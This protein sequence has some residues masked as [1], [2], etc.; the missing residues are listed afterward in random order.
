MHE[1]RPVRAEERVSVLHRGDILTEA[2]T[3]ELSSAAL[4]SS[5]LLATAAA[6]AVAAVGTI[7]CR[8]ER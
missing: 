5:H 7:D 8:G 4:S 1:R 6:A 3:A 2:A